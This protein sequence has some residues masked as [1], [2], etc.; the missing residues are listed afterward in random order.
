MDK[1]ERSLRNK[2]YAQSLFEKYQAGARRL[3]MVAIEAT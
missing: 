3:S 1:A 2:D